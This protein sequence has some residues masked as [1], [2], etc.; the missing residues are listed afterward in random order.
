MVLLL[1]HVREDE[2]GGLMT[3]INDDLC[4]LNVHHHHHHHHNPAAFS[5]LKRGN[6]TRP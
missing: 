2:A 4:D 5:V 6:I 3:F 1:Q